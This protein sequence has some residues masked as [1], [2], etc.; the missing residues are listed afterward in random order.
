MGGEYFGPLHMVGLRTDKS[1]GT[2]RKKKE[3]AS[4]CQSLIINTRQ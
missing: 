4:F 3:K 2:G 1:A